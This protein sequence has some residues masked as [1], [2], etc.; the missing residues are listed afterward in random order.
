MEFIQPQ[1][2]KS[3]S[4]VIVVEENKIEEEES[5]G[6]SQN[7]ENE[8]EKDILHDI[9]ERLE[10]MTQK[11]NQ[12]FDKVETGVINLFQKAQDSDLYQN[13]SEKT[14]HAF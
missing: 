12:F 13:A 1:N 11:A 6:I 3:S 5:T 14:S 7:D 4:V 10:E 2:N 8:E 9:D